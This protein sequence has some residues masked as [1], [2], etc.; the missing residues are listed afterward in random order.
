MASSTQPTTPRSSAQP[1]GQPNGPKKVRRKVVSILEIEGHF[2]I[3]YTT[4]SPTCPICLHE[5]TAHEPCRKTTCQ[6]EFHADCIMKW[7]TKERGKVLNCPTCREAQK[8]SVSKVRQV[9][10]D[11]QQKQ[12]TGNG[13]TRG[14]RSQ[15]QPLRRRQQEPNSPLSRIF[16]SVRC[17]LLKPVGTNPRDRRSSAAPSATAAPSQDASHRPAAQGVQHDSSEVGGIQTV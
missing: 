7:W 9:S 5:I 4:S 12:I 3:C 8:V 10:Q 11:V 14:R 1:N 6:H 16:E 15:S 13:A 2:P 17:A